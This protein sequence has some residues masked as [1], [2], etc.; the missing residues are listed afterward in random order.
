VIRALGDLRK[1][2]WL[3]S[4]EIIELLL[5]LV[6]QKDL[7]PSVGRSI[8]EALNMLKPQN[9]I[10]DLLDLLEDRSAIDAYVRQGI[11]QIISQCELNDTEQQ[12]LLQLLESTDIPDDVL[13]ALMNCFY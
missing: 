12:K 2:N 5:K 10:S 6:R 8:T 9:Y 1:H 4:R 11:A 13:N 7:K 3:R